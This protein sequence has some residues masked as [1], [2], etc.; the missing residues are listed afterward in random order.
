MCVEFVPG[1][2]PLMRV[3]L[4]GVIAPQRFFNSFGL[5]TEPMFARFTRWTI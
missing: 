5:P 3:A 2:F 4:V 1:S